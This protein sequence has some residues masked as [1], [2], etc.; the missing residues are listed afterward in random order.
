MQKQLL[1]KK[2][3]MLLGRGT[4]FLFFID[5][6]NWRELFQNLNVNKRKFKL[7]DRW[8]FKAWTL[9][10]NFAQLAFFWIFLILGH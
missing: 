8:F 3:I 4:V 2:I 6:F 9:G 7:L 1:F 5:K 10:K